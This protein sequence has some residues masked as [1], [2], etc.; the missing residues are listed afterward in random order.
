MA[1]GDTCATMDGVS[2]ATDGR[3]WFQTHDVCLPAT[4]TTHVPAEQPG[5]AGLM[6][7]FIAGLVDVLAFW[8]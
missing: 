1:D 6:V 3:R 2:A 8:T 7:G 4:G 5:L